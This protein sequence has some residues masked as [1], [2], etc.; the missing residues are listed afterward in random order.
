[1]TP[2]S[3]DNIIYS[4]SVMTLHTLGNG[5]HGTIVHKGQWLIRGN[6]ITKDNGSQVAI[7][8]KRQWFTR[9]NGL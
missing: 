8:H 5:S 1:M 2:Q 3:K 9:G 7:A 4:C 6:G